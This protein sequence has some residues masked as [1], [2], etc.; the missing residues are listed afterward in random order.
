MIALCDGW[1][2]QSPRFRFVCWSGW[3]VGL[4]II[5]ALCLLRPAAQDR[6]AQREALEQQRILIQ[7]QW[8]SVYQ[9][10]TS[11]DKAAEEKIVPFSALDFQS[12]Q[13]YLTHWQPSA[14]GGEMTLKSAWYAI[15]P[16][17]ARLAE[18][19]MKVERFSLSAEDA[20]LL[21]M[22][23]LERVNEG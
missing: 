1:L 2:M 11:V 21:F 5:F 23:Q 18:Q 13:T 19:G 12:P 22:L 15:P 6:N 7:A 14:L 4:L 8:R 3:N 17:F 16:M 9:V 10:A 20:G